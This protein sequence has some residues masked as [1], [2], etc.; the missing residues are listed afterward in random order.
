MYCALVRPG[1][2]YNF[3]SELTVMRVLPKSTTYSGVSGLAMGSSRQIQQQTG[4]FFTIKKE[5]RGD[6]TVSL[7]G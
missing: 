7:I 5:H 2:Y 1:N 6:N 4:V 3:S